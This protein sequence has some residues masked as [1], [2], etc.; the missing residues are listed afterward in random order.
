MISPKGL[1]KSGEIMGLVTIFTDIGKEIDSIAN[2]ALSSVQSGYISGVLELAKIGLVL[3]VL[4]Y[5]YAIL[6]GKSQAD[7]KSIIWDFTKLGIIVSILNGSGGILSGLVDFVDEIKDFFTGSQGGSSYS[8]L[9]TRLNDIATL[10]LDIWKDADGVEESLL[11]IL[12]MVA[13]LPLILGFVACGSLIFYTEIVE[14]ILLATAP[15]FIFCLMWGWL[16]DSFSQWLSAILGNALILLF[17]SVILKF[18]IKLADIAVGVNSQ[19]NTFTSIVLCI[20]AGALSLSSVKW[21][22]EIALSLAR[23]SVDRGFNSAGALGMYQSVV[24]RFKG[25][26]NSIQSAKAPTPTEQ[27]QASVKASQSQVETQQALQKLA[28]QISEK[29]K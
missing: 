27:A 7:L 4:V 10:A 28:N 13:L 9:D 22:R 23:V 2:Q 20:I 14:K 25:A 8:L 24:N 29:L 6:A 3:Y 26:K 12:K 5:G 21:G 18:S 1:I 15:I 16:K 17:T 11:A 19:T